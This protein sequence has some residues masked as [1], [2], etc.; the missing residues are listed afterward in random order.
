[1]QGVCGIRIKRNGE[2]EKVSIPTDGRFFSAKS[3]AAH[4]DRLFFIE[5]CV[6]IT[7][8]LVIALNVF[9]LLTS[10]TVPH[11]GYFG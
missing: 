8:V 4:K 6:S 5:C 1:M 7:E 2:V 10:W 9:K 11:Y 3:L